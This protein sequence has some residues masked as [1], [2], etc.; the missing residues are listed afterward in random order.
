MKEK[1]TTHRLPDASVDPAGIAADI[2]DIGS[3]GAGGIEMC[4][5]FMVSQ[6]ATPRTLPLTSYSMVGKL[7]NRQV[8]GALMVSARQLT[9]RF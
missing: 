7:E 1:L 9:T 8:I 6:T 3:I 4:N 2:K 5:Y